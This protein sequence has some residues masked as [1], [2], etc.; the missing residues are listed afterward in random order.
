MR[1]RRTAS[2]KRRRFG[3]SCATGS[4]FGFS[5]IGAELRTP[6]YYD[7]KYGDEFQYDLLYRE[8]GEDGLLHIFQMIFA[9]V[10]LRR[11]GVLKFVDQ[12]VALSVFD[13]KA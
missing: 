11:A 10:R 1:A 4:I 7:S 13:D 9:A 8:I 5:L 2:A 3:T 6:F 12:E